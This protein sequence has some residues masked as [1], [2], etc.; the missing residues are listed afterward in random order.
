[1]CAVDQS[2]G[3]CPQYIRERAW[4]RADGE[5][6]GALECLR[7]AECSRSPRAVRKSRLL[8]PLTDERVPRSEAHEPAEVAVR[9]P[10]LA[11][12]VPQA[13][14]RDAGVVHPRAGNPSGLDLRAQVSPVLGTLR[15]EHEARRLEPRLDLVEGG[16]G[17]RRRIPDP[18][19]RG[20][21][22]ELVD[23]GPGEGPVPRRGLAVASPESL[24][25][26]PRLRGAS[27][28]LGC[29]KQ[30][31]CRRRRPGAARRPRLPGVTA[32]LGVEF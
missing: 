2:F 28:Q 8:A 27:G 24:D 1:V 26:G 31:P 29:R 15:E 18:R 19:M 9:G 11:N 21:R 16:L 10:D 6:A 22:Q 7:C 25:S 4:R 32:S 12:P 13:K 14:G 5:P 20:D 17:R 3:N 23:A 30:K